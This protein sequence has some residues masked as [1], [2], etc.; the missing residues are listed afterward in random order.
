MTDHHPEYILNYNNM[1]YL[2]IIVGPTAV[3]KTDFSVK[4]ARELGAEIIS[5]DS[6]QFYRELNIGTA[7][8]TTVELQQV[9]HHLVG[10]LSVN[11]YYNVS[12]FEKDV[13]EIV[14]NLFKRNRFAVL[15]GGSG[16]YIDVICNGI[17]ELPDAE[18]YLRKEIQQNYNRYGIGYLI[19][20]LSELD[21]VYFGEVDKSN[22]KRLMR[23][24]EVCRATGRKFSDLRIGRFVTRDF[25]IIKIGLNINREVLF[26]RI[27]QR[28]DAMIASGLVEEVRSLLPY[29]Y[30]NALNTVGYKEIFDYIDGNISLENAV[31][32][33]KTNT[34]RY[35]KRQLTW[36]RRDKSI[37]WVEP[38]RLDDVIKYIH[39]K[40]NHHLLE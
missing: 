5:A 35:A 9:K 15:T 4:L 12:M 33:I 1:N 24:I 30:L 28:V 25:G 39:T 19:K 32:N 8:P 16:L 20:E 17:D 11:D 18:D 38:D 6:R 31:K 13:I 26:G 40:T 23:A 37:K 2:V 29:R 34:C 36:F 22:P 7:K 27:G 3:G 14:S 10:H 21:P